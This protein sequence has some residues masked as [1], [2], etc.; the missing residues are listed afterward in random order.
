ML[1]QVILLIFIIYAVLKVALRYKDKVISLQEFLVWTLFWFMVAFV[2]IL[3]ETTSW[4]ANFVGVG[5]GVDLVIYISILIL[6]YLA[7]R[8]LVR[9]DKIEKDVTKIVREIALDKE[10]TKNKQS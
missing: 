8:I 9:L 2:V 5:R 7:F 10:E 4:F 3:P 6:F 1:I